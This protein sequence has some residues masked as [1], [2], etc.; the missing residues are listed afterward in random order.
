MAPV[1]RY[2]SACSGPINIILFILAATLALSGCQSVRL[3]AEEHWRYADLR[4]F[5]PPGASEIDPALDL[6]VVYAKVSTES[7]QFR[8]EFLDLPDQRQS[9][10]YLLIDLLPGG[11]SPD[12]SAAPSCCLVLTWS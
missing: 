6:T 1:W 8:L 5:D 9:D 2:I 7:L 11:A 10:I 12:L 3:P 4:V